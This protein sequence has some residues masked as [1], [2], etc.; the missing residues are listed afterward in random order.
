M[1][2]KII[3]EISNGLN[4]DE[5]IEEIAVN[6]SRALEEIQNYKI[7]YILNVESATLEEK[8]KELDGILTAF[9]EIKDFIKENL[10]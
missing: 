4:E 3:L 2:C 5:K 8:K 7:A 10:K 1:L 9:D 6:I